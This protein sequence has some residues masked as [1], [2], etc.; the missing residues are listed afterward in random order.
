MEEML[1]HFITMVIWSGWEKGEEG[2]LLEEEGGRGMDGGQEGR[3]GDSWWN[4]EDIPS[5]YYL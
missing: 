5:L 1:G 2:G 3:W 4:M